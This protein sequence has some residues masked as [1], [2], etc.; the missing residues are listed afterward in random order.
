LYTP[1][2]H[3]RRYK[4]LQNA[5]A[6]FATLETEIGRFEEALAQWGQEGFA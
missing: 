5:G 2:L 3:R 4:D 1:V 6:M